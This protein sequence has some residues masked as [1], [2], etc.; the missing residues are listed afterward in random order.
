M[1]GHE[2][3][4]LFN[5]RMPIKET[6]LYTEDPANPQFI[7][8]NI[9]FATVYIMILYQ[10]LNIDCLSPSEPPWWG[11]SSRYLQSMFRAEIRTYFYILILIV[12]KFHWIECFCNKG[13]DLRAHPRSLIGDFLVCCFY[14]ISQFNSYSDPLKTIEK[15]NNQKRKQSN[16]KPCVKYYWAKNSHQ[17]VS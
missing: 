3:P 17:T 11:S 9:V 12:I 8:V 13:P 14:F 1:T 2:K 5:V 6:S 4:C 7:L 15:T 10:F 16:P